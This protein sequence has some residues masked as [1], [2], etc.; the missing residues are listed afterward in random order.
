MLYLCTICGDSITFFQDG[1]AACACDFN[2][3]GEEKLRQWAITEAEYAAEV[4]AAVANA[5]IAKAAAAPA[6]TAESG[7]TCYSECQ[8]TDLRP[9]GLKSKG[10]GS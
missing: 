8:R 9:A 1:H 5:R 2:E 3:P 7:S 6:A 4:R 10:A